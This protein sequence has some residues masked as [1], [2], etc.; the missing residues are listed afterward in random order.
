MM[1]GIVLAAGEGR[2]MG[3]RPKAGILL[4]GATLLEHTVR[5]LRRGGCIDILAL[6]P[7]GSPSFAE[8]IRRLDVAFVSNPTPSDGMFSSVLLGIRHLL[9][10]GKPIEAIAILPV[11][12]PCIQHETVIDLF[13]FVRQLELGSVRPSFR[14]RGGHPIVLTVR[15][16]RE[17]LRAP[18]SFTLRD[19][20]RQRCT[21]VCTLPTLDPGVLIN[22]NTPDDFARV[23]A[24]RPSSIGYAIAR[25]S[26]SK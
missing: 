1:A 10:S 20:L 22:I 15:S 26:S 18:A 4:H 16:A 13:D 17:L 12:H 24:Q 2:R 7:G 21:P 19:A 8:L 11:D 23:D 14:G 5:S 25:A 9:S 6:L 3:G